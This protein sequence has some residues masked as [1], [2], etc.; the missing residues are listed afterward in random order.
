[1]RQAKIDQHSRA[2]CD[3]A[4]V[5]YLPLIGHGHAASE[6]LSGDHQH[7]QQRDRR[8]RTRLTQ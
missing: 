6:P 5:R 4:N 1:M 3:E 7:G 2:A 8:R